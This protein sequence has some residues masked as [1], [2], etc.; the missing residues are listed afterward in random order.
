MGVT[1]WR[2]EHFGAPYQ[3]GSPHPVKAFIK[4]LRVKCP[5]RLPLRFKTPG[6]LVQCQGI[7]AAQVLNIKHLEPAALHLDD[8]LGQAGNPAAWKDVLADEQVGLARSDMAN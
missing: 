8:H 1:P 7:V 6:P 4:T 2:A 3:V 5:D